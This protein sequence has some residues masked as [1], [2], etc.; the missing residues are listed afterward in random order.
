VVREEVAHEDGGLGLDGARE[1]LAAGA[2]VDDLA[3]VDA[4]DRTLD[5]TA[6]AMSEEPE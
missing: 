4:G 1:D 3:A 2:G 6:R 5:P